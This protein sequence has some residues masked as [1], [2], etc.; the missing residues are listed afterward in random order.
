MTEIWKG[1]LWNLHQF[2]SDSFDNV[3]MSTD[4]KTLVSICFTKMICEY[5]FKTNVS[6]YCLFLISFIT[7]F[8]WI[9]MNFF[10]LIHFFNFDQALSSIIWYRNYSPKAIQQAYSSIKKTTVAQ[11]YKGTIWMFNTNF[12]LTIFDEIKSA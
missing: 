7:V 9:L 4:T 3:L 5:S 11:T 10:L 1:T 2:T 12:I 8:I 6:L